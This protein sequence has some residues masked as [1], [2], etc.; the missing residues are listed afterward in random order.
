MGSRKRRLDDDVAVREYLVANTD[1]SSGAEASDFEDESYKSEE[2]EEQQQQQPA[3]VPEDEPQAAASGGGFPTWGPPQGRNIT[4]H[5]FVGSAKG[6]KRSEAPHINKDSSPLS[7][8]ML[9][10][11]F[12][13][14]F[15]CWWNRQTCT[16]S[17]T[18][19]NKPDL[20]ADC[21]TLQCQT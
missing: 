21:L 9:F 8:L 14:F 7:V 2:E 20:G 15:T 18:W 17:N 11:F 13:K 12:Q 4:V 3:S 19:T 16:T 5:S 6:V 1:S 10:F